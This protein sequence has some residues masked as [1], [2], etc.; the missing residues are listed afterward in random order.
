MTFMDNRRD[1]AV[2]NCG[3]YAGLAVGWII[4]PFMRATLVPLI[5]E[6]PIPI[7]AFVTVTGLVLSVAAGVII[8]RRDE[9]Q[10]VHDAWLASPEGQEATR[11][12][13]ANARELMGGKDQ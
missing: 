8:V 2:W 11:Q 3:M 1:S 13:D 10:A 6:P 12:A 5:G 4:E 9:Q 7:P